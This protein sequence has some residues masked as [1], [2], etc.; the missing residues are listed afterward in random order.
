MTDAPRKPEAPAAAE[1]EPAPTSG[2]ASLSGPASHDLAFAMIAMHGTWLA[3]PGAPVSFAG[4]AVDSRVVRPK[5]LFFALSGENVDGFDFAGAAAAA[6]AAAIVVE[7]SRGCPRNLPAGVPVIGV[8]D[9]R[10]ALAALARAV[11]ARFSGTVVGVTG[12]NGKTTTKELCAAALSVGGR[13]LRTEGNFNTEIGLPLTVLAAAGDERFWVLEMAMR[14]LGQIAFLAQLARPQIGVITNVASAHL[15]LLGSLENVARAKGE[16]F[17]NL[18]PEGVAIRSA[19]E[20][21]LEQQATEAHIPRARQWLFDGRDADV[22][23]LE[24]VP[25]GAAGTVAR[26][27]VRGVPVVVRLPLAG[28]HNVRNAAAALAVAGAAGLDV[29]AA[30]E[31]L[32]TARLPA[33]RSAPVMIG[34]RMVL[35]DCYNANP[36]SMSAALATIGG[37]A[38]EGRAFAVLGDMLELGPDAPALHRAVGREAASRLVGLVAVGRQA[39]ETAAGAREGGMLR[40]HLETTEDPEVAASV[41]WRWTAPG[42]AIL[43]KGSRGMRLERV[44]AALQALAA[45]G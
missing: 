34:G 31:A 2:P 28:R 5:Q 43:V 30:A 21:L 7:G 35:D 40:A 42:D 10:Q 22:A 38:A 14:G 19:D 17:A 25:A 6:G 26:F 32:S 13:V 24:V 23:V 3:A 37:M 4:G 1:R 36:A 15:E 29:R 20:P 41:A 16:L 27:A 11:R 33:H 44:I 9:A 8:D 45:R 39:G 12:S 18:G